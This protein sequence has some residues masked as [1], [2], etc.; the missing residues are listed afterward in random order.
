[1]K[2]LITSDCHCEFHADNGIAFIEELTEQANKLADVLIIAGDFH[3]TRKLRKYL[4]MVCE[5]SK[6]PVIFVEGNHE[7]Y[8]GTFE[9]VQR[10]LAQLVDEYPHFHHLYNSDVIIDGQRFLGGTLWFPEDPFNAIYEKRFN[11]FVYIKNFKDWVYV[12]NRKTVKYLTRMVRHGD[13]VVTPHAPSDM[14]RDPR[15]ASDDP[16]NRFYVTNMEQVMVHKKPA[17]WVHGHMHN[18]VNYMLHET[19]VVAAPYGYKK[20]EHTQPPKLLEI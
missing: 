14:S 6:I 5:Q 8:R 2:I 13:I 12:E 11:D 1:M 15:F 18:P 20:Y 10:H 9:K 4:R 16:L 3:T 7:F 17:I 19:Q